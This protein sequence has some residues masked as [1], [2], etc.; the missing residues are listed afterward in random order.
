MS[1]Q[2]A[3]LYH[4][5][6][7]SSPNER[8]HMSQSCCLHAFPLGKMPRQQKLATSP[9]QP[10]ARDAPKGWRSFMLESKGL[11]LNRVHTKLRK[12]GKRLERQLP[13]SQQPCAG[14]P[15]CGWRLGCPEPTQHERGNLPLRGIVVINGS[16]VRG[17]NNAIPSFPLLGPLPHSRAAR[18]TRL[19]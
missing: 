17:R 13:R 3:P 4:C 6:V 16:R 1:E 9:S 8:I 12:V 19:R 18:A 10:V 5:R 7:R 11:F 15:D 14:M 2:L